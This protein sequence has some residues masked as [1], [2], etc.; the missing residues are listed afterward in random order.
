MRVEVTDTCVRVEVVGTCV[1]V[2]VTGTCVRVE[3]AGTCIP[4]SLLVE[5][6]VPVLVVLSVTE[7]AV[8]CVMPSVLELGLVISD[9][10]VVIFRSISFIFG[11][12][13]ICIVV[14]TSAKDIVLTIVLMFPISS[15]NLY[16]KSCEVR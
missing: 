1:R 12:M 16:L 14:S 10:L 3:V 6:T 13:I 9:A 2:E 15:D 4:L 5:K 8:D 11:S 7:R